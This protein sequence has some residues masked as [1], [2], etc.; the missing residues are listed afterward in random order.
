M[1]RSSGRVQGLD[2]PGAWGGGPEVSWCGGDG[3]Q[4]G[5]GVGSRLRILGTI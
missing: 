3:G 5:G 1:C 2:G 4:A